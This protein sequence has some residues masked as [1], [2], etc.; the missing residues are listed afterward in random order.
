MVIP[1]GLG[2]HKW[3][4]R[5]LLAE[6][7]Q[8]AALGPAE[9]LLITDRSGEV[10]ETDRANIFAVIGGVLRT[11]LADDRILPGTVRDAIV[12]TAG[13]DGISCSFAPLTVDQLRAASEVFVCN[14]V[15]GILPVRL[16]RRPP[17]HLGT[18]PGG[19]AF[20]RGA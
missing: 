9:Q 4:D 5:R 16:D 11:P 19:Q 2:A 7:A 3:R 20:R 10:L 8:A 15:Y 1:G 13:R 17:G 12:R 18:R 14:A 6:L